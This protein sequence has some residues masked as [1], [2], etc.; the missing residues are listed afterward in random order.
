MQTY[1]SQ[2]DY[3]KLQGLLNSKL[4]EVYYLWWT[5]ED[6]KSFDWIIL[7][8]EHSE[9]CL[10]YGSIAENIILE[11]NL[12][13]EIKRME[14]SDVEIMKVEMTYDQKWHNFINKKLLAFLPTDFSG[15]CTSS[16][17]FNFE[18]NCYVEIM[19]VMDCLEVETTLTKI[20]KI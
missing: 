4:V 10:S 7:K 17:I 3:L 1:L 2:H 8:F 13:E 14:E 20:F 12:S 6:F 5:S 18:G 15:Y 9:I 11:Y 16:I 19:A